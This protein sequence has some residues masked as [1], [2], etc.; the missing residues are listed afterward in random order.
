MTAQQFKTTDVVRLEVQEGWPD[1]PNLI[2]NPSGQG[3]AWGWWGV[4]LGSVEG[5]GDRIRIRT[6]EIFSGMGIANTEAAVKVAPA[7]KLRGAFTNLGL[8]TDVPISN[9]QYTLRKYDA[10]GVQIPGPITWVDIVPGVNSI[11]VQ[12][13]P[14]GTARIDLVVSYNLIGT[15]EDAYLDITD[16]VLMA[17]TSSEVAASDPLTEPGWVDILGSTHEI[18]TERDE[19]DAGFLN[20]TVFD[21]ALDPATDDLIRPGKRCRLLTLV[22]GVW[23]EIFTGELADPSTAYNVRDPRTPDGKRTEIKL[24]AHDRAAAL[25]NSTR[26]NGVGTL[27]EL[28]S[29]LIGTGVP[30]NINGS[31]SAIDP[32]G[33]TVVAVNE[34][35]TALDQVAITRD[36]VRGYA[37]M[38]RTGTLQAWDADQIST[39]VTA[40][41]DEDDYSD[42]N[43]DF[44][45]GRCINT[46][47]VRVSRINPGTGDTEEIELGPYMDPASIREWGQRR[48]EFRVQ[49]V[50]EEDVP[51]YAAAVLAA[52]ATPAKRINEVVLPLRTLDEV[53]AKALTDLY[54]LVELANDRGGITGQRSRV[55][56]VKHSIRADRGRGTWSMTLAFSTDGSVAVPQVTP[57]PGP[58]GKTLAQLLRP[59]GEV[60]MWFGAKADVPAG[61]LPLDGAPFDAEAYPVLAELLGGNVL[62][63]FTDRFPIGAG[64]KAL[65]TGGGAASRVL[66]QNHLPAQI[67][68]TATSTAPGGGENAGLS[69]VQ[70]ATGGRFSHPVST[71]GVGA[72]VDVLNPWRALWFIVRAA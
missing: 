33:V 71:G 17:G 10:S 29:V 67:D 24:V 30:W 23:K 50:L 15:D 13:V 48:A 64:T 27:A 44:D 57:A 1:L 40:V 41:L 6:S 19:L 34:S 52:N 42:L 5:L 37:W 21:A 38:D 22:G 46:V 60:T 16:V 55:A 25:V 7:M 36:T 45:L 59:V 39:A 69:V 4:G 54:D 61:W 56:T 47:V 51:A 11:P 14:S 43:L 2:Q 28:P 62:P 12:N 49:G 70:G 68:L 26:P 20:A 31:T 18:N 72:A 63:S 65:G 9:V 3:G 66:D 35:A 32:T 8:H 53:A 58:A